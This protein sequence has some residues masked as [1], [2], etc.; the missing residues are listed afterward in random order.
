MVWGRGRQEQML[1]DL[2]KQFGVGAGSNRGRGGGGGTGKR[3]KVE[4]R[5]ESVQWRKDE[6][7]SGEMAEPTSAPAIKPCSLLLAWGHS[8][9][10][11]SGLRWPSLRAQPGTF[12]PQQSL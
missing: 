1:P 2:K 10:V 11:R 9:M 4:R 8:G 6:G 3:T 5:L 12:E 7:E